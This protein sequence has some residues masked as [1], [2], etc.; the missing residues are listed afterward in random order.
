MQENNLATDNIS[1]LFIKIV[2][3]S[4]LAMVI[5]GAQSMID[6]L[7]LG[8]FASNNAMA[9][10]NIAMPFLQLS[11][12]IGMVISIGG[13]AF[14]GRM[15]G[16]GDEKTAKTIFKTSLITLIIS[17][18]IIFLVASLFNE[19]IAI[20]LG[21]NEVLLTD[22]ALYIKTMSKFIPFLLIYYLLSFVNRIIGK[23]S[24]FLIGTIV[25]II[26]NILL[27]YVFIAKMNLGVLGAG[28]A[29]GIGQ[30]LGFLINLPPILKKSTI[31]NVYEGKFDIK[32]LLKV[33]YNGSSEGVTSVS[34]AVTTYVF[35]LAFMRY[36]GESGVSAFTIISYMAQVANMIIFGIVDGISPIISYNFGAGLNKRVKS[37]VLIAGIIN[38]MIGVMTYLLI[39]FVGESMISLFVKDDLSLIEITYSGAKIYSTMFFVCG[40]NILASSYF[41]AIGEA[42]KSV[43]VSSS[44][45]LIFILIGV[46]LL[47][48]LMKV[49]GIWLVAP[50]ADFVTF[51]I[52]MVFVKKEIKRLI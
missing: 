24:L 30:L 46:V 52:V 51:M 18:A 41:T 34:M 2:L 15:L 22:S 49:T 11:S 17:G 31:V 7:F 38:F 23:P 6:G 37:V 4:M 3:P 13:T 10:V 12:A 21:A 29:T 50:F 43:L 25:S 20:I 8:N 33:A 35:N 44:R 32:I 26:V 45:G 19:Q 28:Y 14:I 9:S 42:F 47:P 5:I 48:R 36:Y 40:L 1:K 27:N 16:S 39:F